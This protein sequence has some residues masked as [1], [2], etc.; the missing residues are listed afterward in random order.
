MATLPAFYIDNVRLIYD[1]TIYVRGNTVSNLAGKDPVG[2]RCSNNN[3]LRVKNNKVTRIAANNGFSAC[4]S[5]NDVADLAAVYNTASR[6]ATGVVCNDVV[7]QDIY[8]IT[9]HNCFVGIDSNTD[10]YLR[11]AALSAAADSTYWNNYTGVQLSAG[12]SADID[13]IYHYKIANIVTGGT[14]TEGTTVESKHLLYLDEENDNFTPDNVSPAINAGTVNPLLDQTPDIGG[15]NTKITTEV[16]SDPSYWYNLIDNTF[17]D[18]SN[19]YSVEGSLIKAFQSRVFASTEDA[20]SAVVRNAYIKTAESVAKFAETYTMYSRYANPS[21]FAKRVSDMWYSGQNA[22]I[23]QAYQNSIGGYNLLPTF[24]KRMSD[25]ADGWIVGVSYV[26]YDNWLSGYS[27]L[28]YGIGLD[29]LGVS[30]LSR[31]A[32]AE[33]YNN[34]MSSVA[35]VAPVRWFLHDA[36]QPTGYIVFT[37]QYNGFEECVLDNMMYTDDFTISIDAVSSDC[38]LTTGA[39]P[40]ATIM[41][42]SVQVAEISILDRMYDEGIIR[43]VSYRQGSSSAS[44]GSWTEID[45]VISRVIWL[46]ESYV[47]FKIELSGIIRRIDYE[48]IGLALRPYQSAR[49]WTET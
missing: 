27:D 5:F 17:W 11:N 33:C 45:D 30:T 14:Y 9:V 19:D 25:Y 31:S 2:I 4:Y 26:N 10:V 6:A 42:S 15:V 34:V 39:I 44:M 24:M 48:F 49:I 7:V 47:Q 43:T 13:Y 29:V 38:S 28:T 20:L 22:G 37:D 41:A 12:A 35:D 32:L 46:N 3:K 1:S 18:V 21:K 40:T 23:L 36:V 16:F 8:N